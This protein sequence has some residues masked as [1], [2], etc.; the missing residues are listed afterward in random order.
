[1]II[2]IGCSSSN[3][4]DELYLKETEKLA[5]LLCNHN[6]SLM[7]GSSEDG[8]MGTIYKIFKK[9]KCKI[10]SVLPKE[11]YGMLSEVDADEKIYVKQTSDQL[12]Y[13]VNNGDMTI[14]LPGSFG[15]LSELMTSIQ[16]KKLGEHNKPIIIYNINGFYDKI[17]EQFQ[18]FKNENFDLYNQGELYKV[19]NNYNEIEK[20]LTKGVDPNE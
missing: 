6:C 19:I 9:N 8:M 7:F 1:M 14:I 2:F 3:N 13:L 4:V 15:T 17:L 10:I 11:N 12:K 20:Y 18:Q 5:Q 16:C